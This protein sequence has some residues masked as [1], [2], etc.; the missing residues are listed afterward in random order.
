MTVKDILRQNL[1][2]RGFDGLCHPAM[3]CGC[4]LDDLIPC[5]GAQADCQ[6]AYVMLDDQGDRFYTINLQMAQEYWESKNG[7]E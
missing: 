3:E 2:L 7:A 1:K 4:G 6:S 5:E